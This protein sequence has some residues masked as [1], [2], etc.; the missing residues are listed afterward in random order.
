MKSLFKLSQASSVY[1]I[2]YFLVE[3]TLKRIGRG[4][5]CKF[6]IQNELN[7]QSRKNETKIF[8][9]LKKEI[10]IRHLGKKPFFEKVSLIFSNTGKV[11][12][13]VIIN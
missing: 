11:L 4:F 2:N 8:Y 9:N 3:R 5:L 10:R 12:F 6:T 1:T 13:H 7:L